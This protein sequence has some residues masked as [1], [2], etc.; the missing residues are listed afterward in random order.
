MCNLKR[1]FFY[2]DELNCNYQLNWKISFQRIWKIYE[3]INKIK[4]QNIL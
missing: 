4:V 2:K 3:K 1:E